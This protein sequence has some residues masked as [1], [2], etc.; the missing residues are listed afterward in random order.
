LPVS[1]RTCVKTL[2]LVLFPGV[3]GDRDDA[4]C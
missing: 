4:F 2:D 3:R 1:R